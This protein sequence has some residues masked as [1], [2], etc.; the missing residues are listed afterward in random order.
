[1]AVDLFERLA[2]N[3]TELQVERGRIAERRRKDRADDHRAVEVGRD[4]QEAPDE[5]IGLVEIHHKSHGPIESARVV[6][7]ARAIAHALDQLG[8][9]NPDATGVHT[10]GR[11]LWTPCIEIV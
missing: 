11:P 1:V 10:C 3:V 8:T 9:S 7:H 6:A 5:W 2:K 4:L